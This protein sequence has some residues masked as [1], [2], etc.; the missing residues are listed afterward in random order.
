MTVVT[1]LTARP[2]SLSSLLIRLRDRSPGLAVGLLGGAVAAGLGLGAVAVLVIMLWISSPY[3]DGGPGGA[4]HVAA[5]L[6]RLGHGAGLIRAGPLA[7]A[8]APPGVHPPP[9][10]A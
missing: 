7:G 2:T 9:L 10:L 6:W 1:R 8:P 3:P 5:A 4:L